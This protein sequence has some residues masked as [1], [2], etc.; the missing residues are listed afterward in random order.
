MP[1]KYL[2]A[3]AFLALGL[4]V[5]LGRALQPATVDLGTFEHAQPRPVPNPGDVAMMR[6]LA[7]ATRTD[8]SGNKFRVRWRGQCSTIAYRV[9]ALYDSHATEL[10]VWGRGEKSWAR[11]PHWRLIA[12]YG[13]VSRQC[14][15]QVA[16]SNGTSSEV[17]RHGATAMIG[18]GTTSVTPSQDV[19]FR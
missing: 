10:M 2:L 19:P 17:L 11:P 12:A 3:A 14:L 4:V 18:D 7:E 16:A 13:G 6:A 5:L 1:K 9:I 15:E 8:P